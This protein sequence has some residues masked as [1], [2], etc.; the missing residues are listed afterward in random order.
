MAKLTRLIDLNAEDITYLDHVFSVH[1]YDCDEV[2]GSKSEKYLQELAKTKD[3]Y[4]K[5][6]GNDMEVE[7]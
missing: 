7:S 2:Y 3:L 1:V 6:T 4:K 5:L